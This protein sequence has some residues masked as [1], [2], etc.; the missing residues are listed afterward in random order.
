MS[1][2][3]AAIGV[4]L[5][6]FLGYVLTLCPTI[7]VGDS[8][9]LAWA[10]TKLGIA[11]P[12]GYPLWTLLGR[13][14]VAG[15]PGSPAWSLNL[16][17]AVTAAAAA[18]LL[19]A[20]LAR[21]TGRLAVSAG[22]AAAFAF[23]RSVWPIATT[24]EVYALNLLLTVA[25]LAA[26]FAARDGRPRLFL[27]AAYL[28]GLGAANHP[29]ALL[30]G[31]PVVVLA[32]WPS[33]ARFALVTRLATMGALFVLG[34]TVYLYLPIRWQAGPEMVWGGI[35]SIAEI[36][37]HVTRAQYGGLGE[38]SAETSFALRLRVFFRVLGKG[39]PALLG[40][41]AAFGLGHLLLRRERMR[42][43][44]LGGFLVLAGPATAAV[45]RY[46][47]SFLDE[48]VVVPYFLPAVLAV[49][50]LAGIG[51]GALDRWVSV[52]LAA[53]GRAAA[54]FTGALAILV[55]VVVH[56]ANHRD[57]DRSGST[58]ARVHAETVL[59][60]LPPG[61]RLY[62]MGDTSTFGLVYFQR[63][64]GMRPDVVLMD[65]T[66]NL[67]VESYGAEFAALSRPERK[68]RR[69]AREVEIA[70]AE[71]GVPV[72]Y[73]EI[74]DL[75]GFGGC[76]LVPW[77]A[78]H[79]LLRPGEAALSHRT[80][81]IVL[82]AVDRSDF[83]ECHLAGVTLYRQGLGL[84]QEGRVEEAT[85]SFFQAADYGARIAGLLRNLG[86][87]HL[88]LADYGTA[89]ERFLQAIELEPRNQDALYNLAV[90]Y[91]FTG[92]TQHAIEWYERLVALRPEY[93]EVY[94]NWGI[95]LV[96]AGRLAEAR[97]AA[98][99]ALA[100]DGDLAPAVRLR[101]A[102]SLGLEV[103]GEEGTLEARRLVDS[104][105]VGGTLELASRYVQRGEIGK[106]TELYR[107]VAQKNPESVPAIYGLGWGLAKA[108]Q[109]EDAAA[110][111]RRILALEPTNADSRNALAFIFAVTG[112]SLERAE[113]LAEEALAI[114][115]KL[116]AYWYDTL[117]WVRYRRGKHEEA[118]EALRI[119]E[120]GLPS[121]DLSAR[122]E[123]LYHIGAVLMALG[124][125][126]EAAEY[127]TKS[128]LRA[129]DEP[130]VPDLKARARELGIE[131]ASI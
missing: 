29:F 108:G 74:F 17:S 113:A 5:V 36:W 44:V 50:V 98:E 16:L 85:R 22:V 110:A 72:F 30:A 19:A 93:P 42:A 37:D 24:T 25:A 58:L 88:D 97:S 67:F 73:S 92:R 122:A 84:L 77:G 53:T 62:V 20:L 66:L 33:E 13:L 15:L 38:A 3:L 8:G 128:A 46:E 4:S 130:W 68:A 12:P 21:L 103:G 123:N 14:A 26:A 2:A 127:L 109:Y 39:V 99:M 131:E 104:L 117:G 57:C 48:T 56:Q 121:D 95:E 65:R 86:L 45:I 89:E 111:F 49:F 60:P 54:I 120:S 69:D 75:E 112:D 40:I 116:S 129:K 63:V 51:M 1:R 83:L 64:E 124:R 114:A 91:A 125:N 31:P 106:A 115:P 6:V 9:E 10:A 32:C 107:E 96:R 102:A 94:L 105:A 90:L 55:P 79:Q 28:L 41:A 18:G 126:E 118:L 61:A 70:F 59:G 100:I 87:A 119:S 78:L 23:S 35:R 47:D 27:L 11:H 71:P 101:D 52:R 80:E 82:P 34:L 76:R 43:A 81:P 7:F